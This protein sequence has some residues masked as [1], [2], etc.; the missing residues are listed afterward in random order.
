MRLCL[1]VVLIFSVSLSGLPPA[2][3]QTNPEEGVAEG[4]LTPG[5]LQ[6]LEY[7]STLASNRIVNTITHI[8]NI[9]GELEKAFKRL[10]GDKGSLYLLGTVL[11]ILC[12]LAAGF[13]VEIL[14][15]RYTA[16]F[17]RQIESIPQLG[18]IQ[19][20]WSAILRIVTDLLGLFLF[21]LF[22]LVLFHLIYGT[23]RS[24]ARLIFVALLIAVLGSRAVSALSG[25]LFS[26]SQAR[27]R[28]IQWSDAMAGYFHGRLV[29]LARFIGFGWV[30]CLAIYRLGVSR[31]TFLVVVIAVGTIVI[32]MLAAMVWKNRQP[33]SHAITAGASRND[34]S[35][36]WVTDQFAAIWH[37][38]AL[39]YLFIIWL[40]WS[41][42]LIIFQSGGGTFF[43]SLLVVPIF[44]IADRMGQWVVT[45]IMGTTEIK[46]VASPQQEADETPIDTGDT[47]YILVARKI[48]RIFILMAL[49]F[50]LFS[51]W[52]LHLPFGEKLTRATFQI[53]LTLALAHI[54]WRVA[55]SYINRKLQKTTPFEATDKDEEKVDEWGAAATQTRS[56][57]LLPIL[58]KFI[59][60][61]LV[62][63]VLMIGLSS[64]GVNI[65]PLLAGAGVV[66][67]AV[68]FGARKLVSDILSGF[69]FLMD[70]AFRIGEYLKSGNISGMV[71]KISLRNVFLRH[72]R[73]M[74]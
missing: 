61:V 24:N 36:G 41:A 20:F 22:S 10:A 21:T 2:I 62:T 63:M 70:D 73:G 44:L 16:G 54:F 53:L 18:K 6:K 40:L 71:E 72:H 74:L 35:G 43:I 58:R 46:G 32:A 8:P 64:I 19:K 29:L 11:V 37:I 48:V 5:F 49:A 26:P 42:R 3:A 39:G 31:E 38:L 14:F 51:F 52:G 69:F 9:P 68:G 55:N 47:H 34:G 25:T 13:G 60:V 28:L 65:A 15:K 67:L 30:F 4:N 7:A 17:Y 12:I 56:H 66:G 50:W 23:G 1:I 59:G 45:S 33:V 27:L 57:T